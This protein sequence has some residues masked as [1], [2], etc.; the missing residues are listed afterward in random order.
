MLQNQAR[1]LIYNV[2]H[3]VGLVK[4][5]LMYFFNVFSR[6]AKPSEKDDDE[7]YEAIVAF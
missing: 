1:I 3:P 2:F 6:F 5:L 4:F 7:F